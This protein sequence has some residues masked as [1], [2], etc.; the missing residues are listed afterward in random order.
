MAKI[1]FSNVGSIFVCFFVLHFT[2]QSIVVSIKIP[3]KCF[4][5]SSDDNVQF[6]TST[7]NDIFRP[8]ANDR[9]K[10]KFIYDIQ[11]ALLYVFYKIIDQ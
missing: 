3:I 2:A 6:S 10:A 1:I 4:G 7:S 8:S 5:T 9:G 11:L